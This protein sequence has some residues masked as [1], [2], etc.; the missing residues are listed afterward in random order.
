MREGSVGSFSKP[1]IVDIGG[2]ALAIVGVRVRKQ[3]KGIGIYKDRGLG[4]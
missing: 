3:R 2:G 4:I 1:G